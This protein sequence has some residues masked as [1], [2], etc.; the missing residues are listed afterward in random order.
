MW[1]Q[2]LLNNMGLTSEWSPLGLSPLAI[3]ELCASFPFQPFP[4]S[5]CMQETSPLK[6]AW[7]PCKLSCFLCSELANLQKPIASYTE[8]AIWKR[9]PG[10]RPQRVHSPIMQLD[11]GILDHCPP[12]EK[13]GS[14]QCREEPSA[15][16]TKGRV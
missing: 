10:H 9:I 11:V 7:I 13:A 2:A 14:Q 6:L 5:H 8:G 12:D 1:K 4:E 16:I 15:T 3:T